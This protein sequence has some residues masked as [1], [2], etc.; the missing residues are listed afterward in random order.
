[1]RDFP[2]EYYIII[3]DVV[4]PVV[5][6]L[7]RAPLA[8]RKHIK[9]KLDEMVWQCTMHE[10]VEDPEGVEKIVDDFLIFGF[11]STDKEV[12]NS[13]PTKVQV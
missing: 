2:G 9:E 1:M 10:F 12:N 13:L 3:D 8:L 5:H 6:P 11:S 4:P 7:S